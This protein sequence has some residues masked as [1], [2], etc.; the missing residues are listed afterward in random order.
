MLPA[1]SAVEIDSFTPSEAAKLE[2]AK[3]DP[4]STV[5]THGRLAI[6]TVR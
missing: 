1:P 4:Q 3:S 2:D 6:R 5:K